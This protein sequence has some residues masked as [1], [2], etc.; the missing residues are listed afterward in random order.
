MSLGG[1]LLAYG[2]TREVAQFDQ[3]ASWNSFSLH[4]PSHVEGKSKGLEMMR[5][6]AP[7]TRAPRRTDPRTGDS[8]TLAGRS[9]NS[10][11]VPHWS[12]CSAGP[13]S[14]RRHAGLDV[15]LSLT[16][17][18]ACL[19]K[20]AVPRPGSVLVHLAEAP[21]PIVRQRVEGMARH[22]GLEL[23]QLEIQVITAYAPARAP[24]N[25]P[26]HRRQLPRPPSG[27]GRAC[28]CW[29]LSLLNGVGSGSALRG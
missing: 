28:C 27:P 18:T 1:E 14:V 23:Q 13:P 6:P 20:Y 16:S 24:L 22:R 5:Q 21:L 25:R 11:E 12:A 7:P 15:A 17:G 26:Q 9:P 3:S 10:S 4:G 29:I 19:G 8:E 2:I